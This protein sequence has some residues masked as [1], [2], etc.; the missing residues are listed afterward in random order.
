MVRPQAFIRLLGFVAVM[1][2]LFFLTES[3]EH[4]LV[5]AVA[6]VCGLVALLAGRAEE[7]GSPKQR[8]LR[9]ANRVLNRNRNESFGTERESN[10]SRQII[11]LQNPR[12][13][14]GVASKYHPGRRS[15]G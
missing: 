2:G 6:V 4:I 7:A 5:A 14:R 12:P 13:R 1:M 3:D 9:E 8:G 11:R 10:E 15:L